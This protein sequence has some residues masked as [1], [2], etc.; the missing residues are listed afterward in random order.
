MEWSRRAATSGNLLRLVRCAAA[1]A[2]FAALCSAW[3]CGART[4]LDLAQGVIVDDGDGGASDVRDAGRDAGDARY[5]ATASDRVI[6]GG[7]FSQPATSLLPPDR[8]GL[9]TPDDRFNGCRRRGLGGGRA[10]GPV[11]STSETGQTMWCVIANFQG[12]RSDQRD[13]EPA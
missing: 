2:V 6:R 7:V 9:I 8:Y 10:P 3:A 1:L 12:M 4:D 13:M 11:N 5:L